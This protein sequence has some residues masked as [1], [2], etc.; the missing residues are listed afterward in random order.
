MQEVFPFVGLFGVSVPGLDIVL[1][2][3][4][5][6]GIV[7]AVEER[8]TLSTRESCGRRLRVVS[9]S[10]SVDEKSLPL[11]GVSVLYLSEPFVVVNTN[12]LV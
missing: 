3:F 1:F 9:P 11:P 6:G 2:C 12:S 10:F 5:G 8:I 4:E 7:H